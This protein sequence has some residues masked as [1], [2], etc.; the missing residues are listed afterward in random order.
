MNIFNP[1]R[2]GGGEPSPDLTDMF[3]Y[4]RLSSDATDQL[5]GNDATVTEVTSFDATNPPP[6]DTNSAQFNRN[7]YDRIGI[8]DSVPNGS[9]F[10]IN[11]I[12]GFT[13]N[14]WVRTESASGANYILQKRG[15]LATVTSNPYEYGMYFAVNQGTVLQ[16]ANSDGT[17]NQTTRTGSFDTNTW[18]MVTW[19]FDYDGSDWY[20][21]YYK[22][23]NLL[24]SIKLTTS[25]P[26][27]SSN[28]SAPIW[29]GSDRGKTSGFNTSYTGRMAGVGFFNT[30]QTAE[31]ISLIYDYM[32]AGN[33]LI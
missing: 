24:Q 12:N 15:N 19:V 28:T 26:I 32:N 33:H 11:V 25:L 8:P 1:Y 14:M 17:S 7:N 30:A 27:T 5:N 10:T 3:A 21:R 4:Y 22:N 23:G 16:V 18:T 9:D 2:Y 29:L 31:N 20:N 13:V 6:F